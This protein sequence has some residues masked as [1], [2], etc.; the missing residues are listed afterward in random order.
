MYCVFQQV[1]TG[2]KKVKHP[3]GLVHVRFNKELYFY[4]T[5]FTDGFIKRFKNNSDEVI[6]VRNESIPLF[7]IRLY[8]NTQSRYQVGKWNRGIWVAVC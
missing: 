7:E 5:E 4:W 1:A 3:Y 6:T 8:D 2:L